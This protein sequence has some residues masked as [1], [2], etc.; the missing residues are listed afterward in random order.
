ML[1]GI[2]KAKLLVLKVNFIDIATRVMLE[3]EVPKFNELILGLEY[4][5]VK[6]PHFSFTRLDGA[7]PTLGVEMAST[8]EVACLGDD[9]EEAFLKA[10]LSVGYRLP[11]QNIPIHGPCR[12]QSRFSQVYQNAKEIEYE[13]LR[14]TRNCRFLKGRRY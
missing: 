12:D 8:G 2:S 13:T 11:V 6:A 5:G 1:L 10:V 14:H 4:V 9:F 7:D 3:L